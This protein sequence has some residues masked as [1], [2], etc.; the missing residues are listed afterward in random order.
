MYLRLEISRSENRWASAYKDTSAK[1]ATLFATRTARRAPQIV[2]RARSRT[3]E[4]H[5]T[6]RASTTSQCH[7][8]M[9][10]LPLLLTGAAAAQTCQKCGVKREDGQ[11]PDWNCCWSGGSWHGK[12]SESGR[13]RGMADGICKEQNDAERR[14][15]TAT[16]RDILEEA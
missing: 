8:A 13:H 5:S 10:L 9:R 16:R 4:T 12:C 14:G 3:A 7:K 15:R 2:R 11:M 6:A 1:C